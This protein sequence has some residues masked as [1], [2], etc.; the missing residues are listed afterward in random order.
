MRC[1]IAIDDTDSRL[2]RCTTHLGFRIVSS[3]LSMGCNFNHYPRLIRLNPNIP[4]KTRGNAAVCLDFET[5]R[6]EAA[7]ALADSLMRELS[8]IE[9][10]AN[11]GAVFVEGD[12]NPSVFPTLYQ[13][14]LSGLVNPR[15]VERILRENGV[16]HSFLGN[17]MGLVGASACLGFD[18]RSDHTYELLAYRLPENL[19]TPR[20][21][22]S[23]SVIRAER[24][25]FPH[26]FNC[27]DYESRRALITP[28]GPDPV[29][30]GIRADSP[31]A[32]LTAMDM[33]D[34]KEKLEGYMVYLTN[35]CTDAHLTSP[36]RLPLSAYNSGWLEGA[37][38]FMGTGE[39]GHLYL[40]L[41]AGGSE[42]PMVV[43][44]Q[45]GD[46]SRSARLLAPGDRVRAFGGVRRASS[47]H[48]SIL[49]VEKLEVLQV[50]PEVEY[51]NPDCDSCGGSTKSEG[52]GKGFQCRRCGSKPSSR[53]KVAKTIPREIQVGI[54]LPSSG[55]QRHLTKQLMRYG[56]ETTFPFRPEG[57]WV[58]TSPVRP[59]RVPA[60]NPR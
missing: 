6:P 54:Y 34:Y 25:M 16:R 33:L 29:F 2:G 41:D 10:G 26:C 28:H 35:Q 8:D 48:L 15:R 39:G 27:F 18:E 14:A 5:D 17:G 21:V 22:D 47:R 60:Q 20:D 51:V 1:L 56:R 49:N 44:A 12:P 4:F 38:T 13:A 23:A 52:R 24:E 7:F 19:G 31:K 45:A 30:F 57:R 32:A 37:V 55:S 9:N 42:V 59:L 11:S 40:T 43:Y 36:L 46:L 3:L 58:Q 50:S 53:S